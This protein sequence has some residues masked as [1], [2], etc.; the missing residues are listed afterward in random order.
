MSWEH[1]INEGRVAL[2]CYDYDLAEEYFRKA[3]ISLGKKSEVWNS[4]FSKTLGLLGETLFLKNNYAE[5]KFYFEQLE[6]IFKYPCDDVYSRAVSNYCLGEIYLQQGNEDTAMRFF[7]S[8]APDLALVFH[9]EHRYRQRIEEILGF[10]SY[11]APRRRDSARVLLEEG[12]PPVKPE[13][14]EQSERVYLVHERI[15]AM[16]AY[17]RD[18]LHMET[19][20]GR[21]EAYDVLNT[22][23]ALS[24]WCTDHV[25]SDSSVLLSLMAEIAVMVRADDFAARLAHANLELNIARH[26]ELS[27]EVVKA[28]EI[29]AALYFQ[30]GHL[31]IADE[32][33]EMCS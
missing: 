21:L 27:V 9:G 16:L 28:K 23:L 18:L 13:Q 11:L 26:G 12:N 10:K 24:T 2:L 19:L 32:L 17:S 14:A 29:L 20:A 6:S 31:Q 15:T 7:K 30:Q 1:L 25:S 4:F 22:A 8:A 5:A 3:L 33:F